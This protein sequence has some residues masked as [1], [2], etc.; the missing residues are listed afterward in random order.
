M[1]QG[2][3][4]LFGEC[5]DRHALLKR[6]K[7]ARPLAPWMNPDEI[8]KLQAQRDKLRQEAHKEN[9]DD[10]SWV[11]FRAVRNNI[12]SVINKSK[13]VF[14]INALSSKRPKE[15]CASSTLVLSLY[16]RTRIDLTRSS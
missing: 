15:V 1:V 11:A 12:E 8:R 7:V 16:K 10:D 6:S 13:R 3:K 9:S 4:T 14:F 5:I 2:F